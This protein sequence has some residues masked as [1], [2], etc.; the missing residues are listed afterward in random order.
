MA[1]TTY[2]H[3]ERKLEGGGYYYRS[4]LPTR[5]YSWLGLPARGYSRLGPPAGYWRLNPPAVATKA[6]MGTGGTYSLTTEHRPRT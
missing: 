2:K 3:M 5:F 4:D 6:T 1:T